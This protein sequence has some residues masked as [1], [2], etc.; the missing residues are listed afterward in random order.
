MIGW[1]LRAPADPVIELGDRRLPVHLVRRARARRMVLRLA[2][3]GEAVCITLP[4]WGSTADA[5]AFAQARRD[6]LLAQ[7]ARTPAP[8]DPLGADGVPYRGVR[9]HVHWSPAASR[10]VERRDHQLVVGGAH[11]ALKGRLQRWLE[12]EAVRL[13]TDDLAEFAGRA[14]VAA[15]PLRLSR[16]RRRWGSCAPGGTVRINWRLVQAPDAVRRAVV[17]HEV[18]HLVHFD[19]SPAFHAFLRAIG[20]PDAAEADT[21]L[22]ANGPQLFAAF[23]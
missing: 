23:G 18:A 19:H 21:W 16:A 11:E 9:L 20:D 1:L 15:P 10:R 2:P 7:L 8:F 6:W 14:G 22:R 4:P 17:A 3:A 5:L 12:A 13:L